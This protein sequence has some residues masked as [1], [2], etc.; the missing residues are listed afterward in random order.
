M[1]TFLYRLSVCTI[2]FCVY[3]RASEYFLSYDVQEPRQWRP[4]TQRALDYDRAYN[5]NLKAQ[6]SSLYSRFKSALGFQSSSVQRPRVSEYEAA[7]KEAPVVSG[8]G[9]PKVNSLARAY[10]TVAKREQEDAESAYRAASKEHDKKSVLYMKAG[11]NKNNAT[12]DLNNAF[13]K[14]S[15]KNAEYKLQEADKAYG[16]AQ[17]A[18][19]EADALK[20]ELYKKYIDASVRYELMRESNRKDKLR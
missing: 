17:R 15:K 16:Q 19:E 7:Y 4:Q 18:E 14:K 11:I 12:F 6:A 10:E 20:Q 9:R 8:L 13:F 5:T 1:K 3:V 2:L